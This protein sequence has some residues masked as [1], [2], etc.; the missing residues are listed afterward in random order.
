MRAGYL[1]RRRFVVGEVA[2]PVAAVDDAE[3]LDV[4]DLEDKQG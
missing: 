2:G 1:R 3:E 4:P